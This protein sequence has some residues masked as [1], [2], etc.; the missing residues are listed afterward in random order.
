MD[1]FISMIVLWGPSWAPRNWALCEGQLLAISTNTALF[2]LI[3]TIYG[4]DGRTT[5]ALPDFRGRVPIGQGTGPGLTPYRIGAKGGVESVTLNSLQIP[6]HSHLANTSGLSVVIEASKDYADQ[7]EPG[8]GRVLARSAT[9][10]FARVNIYKDSA[11]NLEPLAGGAV[12]GTVV[13]GNTG[14]SQSHTNVQ[15]FQVVSFIMALYGIFPSRN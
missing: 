14:G 5:F 6:S 9:A 4:G 1:P 11:T 13:I 12:G 10:S 2:S 15:P 3:G 7:D 8:N